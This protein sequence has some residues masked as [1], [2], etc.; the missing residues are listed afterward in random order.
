MYLHL[1]MRLEE[2]EEPAQV[3]RGL[4]GD[5]E[6]AVGRTKEELRKSGWSAGSDLTREDRAGGGL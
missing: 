6:Y 1:F 3:T 4:H 5:Q 2:E